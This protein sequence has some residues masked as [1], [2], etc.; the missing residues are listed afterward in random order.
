MTFKTYT[1]HLILWLLLALVSGC[2]SNLPYHTLNSGDCRSPAAQ[3]CLND[4]VGQYLKDKDSKPSLDGCNDEASKS[5]MNSYY[6]RHENFDL[7]V[8]EFSERGNAFN[9][10]YIDDVLAQIR[11][12]AEGDGVILITFVHGWKHNA[13]ELDPNLLDFK[14]ALKGIAGQL[15]EMFNANKSLKKRRLVGLYIGWRGASIKAPLLKELTFWDRKAVAQEV[16][17]GG[18]TKLLLELA[19]IDEGTP[20]NRNN[21]KNVL[22]VVGHSFGGAIVVSALSEVLT[23]RNLFRTETRNYGAVLGDSVIVLNPAIEANQALSLVEAAIKSSYPEDQHPML[24]SISTDADGATHKLFPIGQTV[25]LLLTW[26]QADL[27]RN[28]Y[29]DRKHGNASIP[30]K[31]E[32]L[33]A[34]TV[35]NFAPYLTH[36]LKIDKR[37]APVEF[38]LIK[39]DEIPADCE[40]MGLTTL[41]GQPTINP[42]PDN[43]PLYFIKTDKSVMSGH[44]DIFNAT[45]MSFMLAVIDDVVRRNLL[46]EVGGYRK[47]DSTI[48][49]NPD[50]LNERAN[51]ML[52]MLCAQQGN[53]PVLECIK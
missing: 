5:C 40:P 3:Q 9:Q 11:S 45:I 15:D 29:I 23:E 18:V 32:H 42:L 10:N 37:Q 43:Y 16:G 4:I 53:K 48:L 34:T 38:N 21:G 25:G 36:R 49:S 22:V 41:E 39:C 28:Y 35:G 33:D 50:L 12:Y 51:A 7:A 30:L 20:E 44:N 26:K 1:S 52:E 31:E 47:R 6:Q 46:A 2:T 19:K 14:L 24:V 17:K 13:N 27:T 8:A